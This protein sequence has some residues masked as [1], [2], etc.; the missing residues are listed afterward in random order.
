VWAPKI[1]RLSGRDHSRALVSE[2]VADDELA[3]AMSRDK[4]AV[5]RTC[6]AGLES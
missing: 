4:K 6:E 2:T 1:G 3:E 5:T